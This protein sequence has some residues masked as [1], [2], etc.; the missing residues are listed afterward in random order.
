MVAIVSVWMLLERPASMRLTP[1]ARDSDASRERGMLAIQMFPSLVSGSQPCE[2]S[3]LSPSP[4]IRTKAQSSGSLPSGGEAAR[5][6][7]PSCASEICR[8]RVDIL[9]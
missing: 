3:T 9:A 1:P 7:R 8:T 5:V 4:S 6:C 2:R